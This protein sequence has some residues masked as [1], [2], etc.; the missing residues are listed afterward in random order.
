MRAYWMLA[1]VALFLLGTAGCGS[2]I[3]PPVTETVPP[4][5]R[6]PIHI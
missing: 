2:V 6:P 3:T 5:S 4:P 1:L